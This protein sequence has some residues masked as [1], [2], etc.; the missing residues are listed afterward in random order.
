M[1]SRT[2]E[3]KTERRQTNEEKEV[4]REV[5]VNDDDDDEEVKG[6]SVCKYL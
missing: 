2:C 4:E 5:G 1:K 6:R 3:R